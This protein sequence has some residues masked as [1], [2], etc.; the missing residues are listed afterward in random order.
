MAFSNYFRPL[1]YLKMQF[2]EVDKAM[3]QVFKCHIKVIFF[4]AKRNCHIFQVFKATI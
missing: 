1:H 3:I 2:D 4:L